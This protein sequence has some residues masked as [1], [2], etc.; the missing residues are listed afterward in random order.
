MAF[1]V[2][3]DIHSNLEALNVALEF[4]KTRDDIDDVVVLGDIVGY[5]A[6]PNECITICKEVSDTIVLG[7]HDKAAFDKETRLSFNVN[8]V[9][10]AEWTEENLEDNNIMFL[11]NLPLTIKRERF[12]FVHSSP[13]NPG[14][15]LYISGMYDAQF[16]VFEQSVCFIG[17]THIPKIYA[18][19]K[20]PEK[21]NGKYYLSQEEKYV[22]NVGSI[23]QPRDRNPALSF[24]IFNEDEW[25][26]E[27]VRLDY[28]IEKAASKIIEAGL[29]QFLAERLYT[30]H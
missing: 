7:N 26:A 12:L 18:E 29:P 9:R 17:H 13:H 2:I 24:V 8:A 27:Y 6:N 16:R 15:W 30:G 28:D 19:G 22:I 1:A 11:K 5:G 21:K 3:S 20:V 4:I 25:S 10:S 14:G 23:G